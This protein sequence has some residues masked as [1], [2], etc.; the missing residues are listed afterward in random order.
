MS[1]I[2]TVVISPAISSQATCY[3]SQEGRQK[4]SYSSGF[5]SGFMK[6]KNSFA[7]IVYVVNPKSA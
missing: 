6:V 3:L 7:I 2:E 5:R 4:A 1:G